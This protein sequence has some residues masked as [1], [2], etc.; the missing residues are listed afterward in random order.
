M[1]VNSEILSRF[2][3]K[4]EES[5]LLLCT[6]Y[7]QLSGTLLSSEDIDAQWKELAPHYVA[8][9]VTQIADYPTVSVAWAGYLG[10]AVAYGWDKDWEACR[11]KAY[12]EYYGPNGFDDMDEHILYGILSLLPDGYEAKG[13]E[14]MMRR[15]GEKTVMLIRHEQIEPQSPM[16]FH[17]FARSC[18]VMFRIG[19]AI[20]L[21]C[22]G[23]KYQE[24]PCR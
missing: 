3:K 18:K 12:S 5:L 19:A 10:M 11:A 9:A 7:N 8:D 20:E 24:I 21:K 6:S 22:L 4:L 23:Y 14:D 2:E 15:C 13:L 17:I 1:M 16:A